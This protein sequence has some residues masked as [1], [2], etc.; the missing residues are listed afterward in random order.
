LRALKKREAK[1][2]HENPTRKKTHARRQED[3][4]FCIEKIKQWTHAKQ[5]QNCIIWSFSLS[6][7]LSLYSFQELHVLRL[8]RIKARLPQ[9]MGQKEKKR[10][11]KEKEKKTQNKQK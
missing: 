11:Q 3:I 2:K 8:F 6:L 5:G 10:R 4:G 9:N 7:S 1:E